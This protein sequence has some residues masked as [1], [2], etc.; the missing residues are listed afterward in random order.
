MGSIDVDGGGAPR[1]GEA[2]RGRALAVALTLVSEG[3]PA[4][5]AGD[6][7]GCG[8]GDAGQ[9]GRGTEEEED[10]TRHCNQLM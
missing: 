3:E 4:S 5:L 10:E 7:V 2:S 1:L 6:T 8:Q 9:G